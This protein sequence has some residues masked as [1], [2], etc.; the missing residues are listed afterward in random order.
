MLSV[1]PSRCRH[2]CRF[3]CHCLLPY[4][5][6]RGSCMC[7][8]FRSLLSRD[9]MTSSTSWISLLGSRCARG[10]AVRRTHRRKKFKK[11]GGLILL[12]RQ[13]RGSPRELTETRSSVF[14]SFG[15]SSFRSKAV[16][17]APRRHSCPV[18]SPA[19]RG[20]MFACRESLSSAKRGCKLRNTVSLLAEQLVL[21]HNFCGY[22]RFV[23]LRPATQP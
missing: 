15:F 13:P 3:W 11:K 16:D 14:S 22:L 17:A 19:C 21:K 4:V 18:I 23:P 7:S 1:S 2:S 10:R 20:T 9:R 5:A 12:S 8:F 6:L